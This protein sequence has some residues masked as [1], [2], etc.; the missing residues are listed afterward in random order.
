MRIVAVTARSVR[1]PLEPRGAARG[2]WRE[3]ESVIVAVRT[4]DGAT[5][6][7]EAAP[8]PGMSIDT[9]DDAIRATTDLAGCVPIAIDS[10]GHATGV[11]DRITAAPAARF[12]IET[13]LLAALAQHARTRIAALWSQ[14]PHAELRSAVV[15][16]DADGAR[17]AVAAGARCVKIKANSPDLVLRIAA[18]VPNVRLRVDANR[19]WPRSEVMHWLERLALLPIDFVEE[20]CVDAHELL[21]QRLPCRI[22]LDE[23]LVDLDPAALARALTS[24]E[25]AA[26]V[27]K[28][29]LLGGFARCIELAAL[30]HRHGVAPIVSHSLEGPIGFAACIELARTIG[31][32]VPVGLA[33]HPGLEQFWEHT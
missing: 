31:A 8:L 7:G 18:A 24:P 3:R 12:A 4:E 17:A 13:A 19:S 21:A 20:P 32:D 15:C 29:T 30:A 27:C 26:L 33:P 9:L 16:D 25:L 14:I 22:A 10:P 6:L 2:R 28:P 23:S 1:W 11:A 5:G